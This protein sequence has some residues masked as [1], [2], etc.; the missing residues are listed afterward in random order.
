MVV[1]LY[2]PYYNSGDFFTLKEEDSGNDLEELG[3][4]IVG[5]SVKQTCDQE[6]E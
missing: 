5:K 4:H 6:C 1:S 2:D 3:C